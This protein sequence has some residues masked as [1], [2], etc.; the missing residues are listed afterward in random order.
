[1]TESPASENPE[2]GKDGSSSP[3]LADGVDELR[4]LF[5]LAESAAAQR[6]MARD[7][8]IKAVGR[9]SQTRGDS[10]VQKARLR[11]FIQRIDPTFHESNYGFT[12]FN[13]LL[14][15]LND[16]L[17]TRRGEFDHQLRLRASS[18]VPE[19]TTDGIPR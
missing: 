14:A 19:E 11:P 15:S 18:A 6:R 17:E 2:P 1:L 7:L 8:V 9:L 13:E 16:V 10:W 4:V 12:S 5:D 3:A